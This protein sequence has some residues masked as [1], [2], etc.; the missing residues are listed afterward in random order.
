MHK[1]GPRWSPMTAILPVQPPR[2]LR[3]C[4]PYRSGPAGV[5]PAPHEVFGLHRVV[6]GTT[7]TASVSS[8]SLMPGGTPQQATRAVGDTDLSS[9]CAPRCGISSLAG[10]VRQSRRGP[11]AMAAA[12]PHQ[13]NSGSL[14]GGGVLNYRPVRVNTTGK[15]AP[16]RASSPA[17]SIV[18]RA[19]V[20]VVRA[21]P[22]TGRHGI[23]VSR[24]R[25]SLTPT[26][27]GRSR[28]TG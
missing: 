14:I 9:G 18:R 19:K 27:K 22:S 2:R 1:R 17:P 23:G 12:R 16:V 28:V 4:G 26:C 8:W 15:V 25:F 24:S 3:N 13:P 7:F 6:W 21:S 20:A 11:S 5:A 10:K